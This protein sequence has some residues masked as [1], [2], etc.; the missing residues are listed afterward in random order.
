MSTKT[1]HAM[2]SAGRYNKLLTNPCWD[3]P[4]SSPG[5]FK[6]PP[7]KVCAFVDLSMLSSKDYERSVPS[8][9][10]QI[11]VCAYHKMVFVEDS[12]ARSRSGTCVQGPACCSSWLPL[13]PMGPI[14]VD[15]GN[16]RELLNAKLE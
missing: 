10:S 16:E 6:N 13:S 14:D 8:T 5:M 3:P 4:S 15:Q 12:G 9:V 7:Q 2:A 11:T 1:Q